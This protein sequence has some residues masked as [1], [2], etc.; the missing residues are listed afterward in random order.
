MKSYSQNLADI[1]QLMIDEYAF[2][3]TKE[4]FSDTKSNHHLLSNK[5]RYLI[6]ASD[7]YWKLN[8]L[9]GTLDMIEVFLTS[10]QGL[11]FK[12]NNINEID[13]I[14]YHLEVYYHKIH[15]ILE[16]MKLATNETFQ[17]GIQYKD[18]NWGNIQTLKHRIDPNVLDIIERYYKSFKSSIKV[19]NHNT[20]RA[21]NVN[22]S[23]HILSIKLSL[24]ENS[25]SSNFISA[26]EVGKDI[27]RH[28]A[29][30]LNQI[31]EEK[32]IAKKYVNEFNFK[33]IR[34]MA[35]RVETIK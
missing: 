2:A 30:K 29:D 10:H 15:T 12:E 25:N 17:L 11:K 32:G 8:N 16:L 34:E 35:R 33:I 31:K 22:P 4:D 18:C 26:V 9:I 19:R 7:P 27:Q 1:N 28:I 21:S 24:L 23:S 6:D 3:Q 14:N 13:Y 5:G 20:H